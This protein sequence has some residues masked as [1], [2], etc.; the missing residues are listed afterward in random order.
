MSKM[1]FAFVFLASAFVESAAFADTSEKE[2]PPPKPP[3]F[4][5]PKDWKVIDS[6]P[7]VSA[8]FQ[9][10]EKDR[11]ATVLVMA[12]PGNGGG[13]AANVNRW[14]RQ[15]KLDELSEEAVLKTLKAIKVD[16]VAAHSVD[17]SGRDRTDKASER[18]LAV[19]VKHGE[20]TWFFKMTGPFGFVKEQVSPFEEFIKSVRFEK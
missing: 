8:R 5:A 1:M 6:G 12:L 20:R 18:M 4:E 14:R 10:G 15:L 7:L 9:I 11:I 3:A 19:I 13:L 2:S 17:L 16:G